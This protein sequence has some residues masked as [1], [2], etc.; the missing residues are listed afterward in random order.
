MMSESEFCVVYERDESGALIRT[1]R[2]LPMSEVRRH[3]PEYGEVLLGWPE[4]VVLWM[5]E[6]GASVG[7][8]PAD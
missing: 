1:G 6:T 8:A 7:F 2:T 5:S 3:E 4:S